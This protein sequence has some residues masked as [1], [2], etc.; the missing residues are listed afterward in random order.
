M[1]LMKD[2]LKVLVD[3]W[4]EDIGIIEHQL[5]S[6][7]RVYDPSAWNFVV[8]KEFRKYFL[9]WFFLVD[10]FLNSSHVYF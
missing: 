10:S 8:I 7:V 1:F 2:F 9:H 6:I 5:T 4:I 3:F